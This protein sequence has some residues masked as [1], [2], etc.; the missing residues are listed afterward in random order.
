VTLSSL[1]CVPL[2][3]SPAVFFRV[4]ATSVSS[5]VCV[6][7]SCVKCEAA[8]ALGVPREVYGPHAA[9]HKETGQ[10]ESGQAI[11]QIRGK[12]EISHYN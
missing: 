1:L 10:C 9:P 7:L 12:S 3:H 2:D 4:L 6:S 11:G 8:T 5:C